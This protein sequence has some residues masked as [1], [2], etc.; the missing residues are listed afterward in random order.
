[1]LNKLFSYGTLQFAEVQKQ[2]F[3]RYLQT[4]VNQLAGF[5]LSQVEITD[6][7]VLATSG[8][9][10]HP[11]ISFTGNPQDTV[12]G[13]IMLLTEQEL[14]QA[15]EYEVADYKRIS[16]NTVDGQQVW[17]YVEAATSEDG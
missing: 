5:T 7:H 9:R 4:Q 10:F 2:T 3:G 17:V 16:A 13:A 15:D 1:M 14:S 6:P 8:E 12:D 11:I